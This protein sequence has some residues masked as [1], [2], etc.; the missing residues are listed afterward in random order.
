MKSLA[1]EAR[2]LVPG[3]DPAV[4]NRFP[5]IADRIVKIE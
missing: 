1:G 4:F 3:H 5:K 2:L